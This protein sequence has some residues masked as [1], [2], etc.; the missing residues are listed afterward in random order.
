MRKA[1]ALRI[2]GFVGA[3]C[4]SAAL[5]GT[6][7]S[8]TGAYFTDSHDGNMNAGTGKIAVTISPDNGQ[9]NFDNLL[10]GD[11]QT[12]TVSYTAGPVGGTEDIWLVFPNYGTSTDAFTAHPQAGPAPL[13]QYGHLAVSSAA[14]SF[15]SYNLALS[16]S[17]ENAADSCH[18]DVNGHG[19]SAAQLADPAQAKTN[20]LPYCAPAKAILLQSNMAA[21]DNGQ[22]KITFGFTPLLVGGQGMATTPLE[23]YQVVATQHGIRPDDP[24]NG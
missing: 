20:P 22:V 10:P 9:L 13:G 17:G 23:S 19:G 8:G 21:G 15:T 3:L 2:T 5:V 12:Q 14:G 4:A 7:V 6:S 18:I 1:K 11:Y 16:P 24:F